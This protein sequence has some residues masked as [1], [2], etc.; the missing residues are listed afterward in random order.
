MLGNTMVVIILQY[1]TISNQHIHTPETYAISYVNYISA[2]LEKK[3][4][5]R[6]STLAKQPESGENVILSSFRMRV[7]DIYSLPLYQILYIYYLISR[8]Q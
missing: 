8:S 5:E 7:N 1:K 4:V 3:K 6:A 2:K